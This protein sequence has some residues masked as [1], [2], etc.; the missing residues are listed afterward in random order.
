MKEYQNKYQK[1]Y[2]QKNKEKIIAK[3]VEWN[4]THPDSH[5]KSINKW[6][7]NHPD[8]AKIDSKKYY[9]AHKAEIS[10]R[11]KLKRA[12]IEANL[13]YANN[14]TDLITLANLRA[15][16]KVL[17]ISYQLTGMTP[18]TITPYTHI[19]KELK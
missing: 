1:E 14:K 12:Q 18:Y 11:R 19:N 13:S 4:K 8:R 9:Y 7:A 17:K 10:L 5:K 16:A 2:Y 3:A 15:T 6:K